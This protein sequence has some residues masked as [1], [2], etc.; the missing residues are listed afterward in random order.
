MQTLC[1]STVQHQLNIV[2]AAERVNI[3]EG[4]HVARPVLR[5]NINRFAV[6]RTLVRAAGQKGVAGQHILGVRLHVLALES[7]PAVVIE[8]QRK[9]QSLADFGFGIKKGRVQTIDAPRHLTDVGFGKAHVFVERYTGALH[10]NRL[11]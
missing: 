5:G 9:Q 10:E 11:G 8:V 4:V 6:V 2:P 7:R 3:F 1:R